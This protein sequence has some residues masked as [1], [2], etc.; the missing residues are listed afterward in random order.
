MI[1]EGILNILA[2]IPNLL[3]DS[4]E[5]ISL[6]I[7]NNIFDGLNS[8][9]NCLGFLFPIKGLLVILGISFAIKSFQIIWAI[10][11]RIKSFIPTMGA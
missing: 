11:L 5:S 10:V 1:T 9:F 8:I 2:F 7:P 3:L 6:S 4:M